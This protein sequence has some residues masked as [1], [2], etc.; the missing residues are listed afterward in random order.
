MKDELDTNLSYIL[1]EPTTEEKEEQI[2]KKEKSNG[3]YFFYSTFLIILIYI[4]IIFQDE[5]KATTEQLISTYLTKDI[6]KEPQIYR[7]EEVKKR[8]EKENDSLKS[9]NEEKEVKIVE[10]FIKVEPTK[11]DLI[12]MFNTDNFKV[13]KCTN[14]PI[15]QFQLS[16]QC[17]KELED[18]L[19]ENKEA[20]R[21]EV[22]PVLGKRDVTVYLKYKA[23]L[24][25][26]LMSGISAKRTNEMIWNIKQFLPE[27]TL[28]TP[29]DYYIKSDDR[30]SSVMVKAYH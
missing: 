8:I 7:T 28:I 5:I 10:R 12:R 4:S 21:F 17:K 14:Y 19:N 22:I 2:K 25:E 13:Y 27:D 23:Y 29:K 3:K 6:K 15:H 16:N 9:Y 26:V 30:V 20:F 1:N 18:F 11:E 24:E